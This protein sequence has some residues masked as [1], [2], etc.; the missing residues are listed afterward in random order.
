MEDHS[1]RELLEAIGRGDHEALSALY[2]RHADL[3]LAIAHR[4]LGVRADAEDVVHDVFVL[5]P[6]RARLYDPD[7][8]R[9]AAWL[10]SIV[11]N[12][13]LDQ[14]RRRAVR[15]ARRARGDEGMPE[16]ERAP[17][18]VA[19]RNIRCNRLREVMAA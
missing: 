17:D 15:R 13:S 1:D 6:E 7:L 8:G 10:T 19:A 16:S 2:D 12:R 3:L 9:V 4:I 11:K 14:R 18:S 5:L